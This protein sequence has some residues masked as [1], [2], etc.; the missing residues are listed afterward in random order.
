M[1]NVLPLTSTCVPSSLVL[2]GGFNQAVFAADIATVADGTAPSVYSN[3]SQFYAS[4]YPTQTLRALL[5]DVLARL[6]GDSAAQSVLR[7]DSGLGGGKTHSLIALWHAARGGLGAHAEEFSVPQELRSTP[8]ARTAV[9]VGY[10]AGSGGGGAIHGITPQTIW[11][12]IALQ[13]SGPSGYELIRRFDEELRSPGVDDLKPILHGSPALIVID[14]IANYLES[15]AARPVPNTSFTLDRAVRTFVGQILPQAVSATENISLVITTTEASGVYEDQTRA[16]LSETD[17]LLVRMAGTP[18]PATGEGDIP[19]ILARRLF[20]SVDRSGVGR[21]ADS[22]AALQR[23]AESKGIEFQQSA[24]AFHEQVTSSYPFHPD[25]IT[26]LDKRL[27]TLPNFQRTRGALRLL[28]L[29]VHRAW[30]SQTSSVVLHQWH[31]DLGDEL[32][33]QE[34]TVKL[35]RSRLEPVVRDDVAG[36]PHARAAQITVG[37]E[38]LPVRLATCVLLGSLAARDAGTP[39]S[40]AIRAAMAPGDNAGDAETAIDR[41][42]AESFYLREDDRGLRYSEEPS[43]N[44]LFDTCRR[45]LAPARVEEIATSLYRDAFKPAGLNK[46]F[47]DWDMGEPTDRDADKV[48]VCFHWTKQS[49]GGGVRAQDPV[50]AAVAERWNGPQGKAR[51]NLNNMVLLAPNAE[52]KDKFFDA[53]KDR[54]AWQ[55]LHEDHER[56]ARLSERDRATLETKVK[57]SGMVARVALANYISVLYVPRE[58]GLQ[59]YELPATAAGSI[60]RNQT[61]A[62]ERVLEGDLRELY[63]ADS[64]PL[65]V[66]QLVDQ[67]LAKD[68]AVSRSTEWLAE[69]FCRRPELPI[70]LDPQKLTEFVRNGVVQGRWA[71]RDPNVAHWSWLT[72]ENPDAFPVRIASDTEIAPLHQVPQRPARIEPEPV[73]AP[74]PGG[75]EG[76]ITLPPPPPLPPGA[77]LIKPTTA[78]WSKAAND[79]R[80]E[81]GERAWSKLTATTDAED[82]ANAAQSLRSLGTFAA[83]TTDVP[84]TATVTLHLA[85]GP[86]NV[87]PVVM[88]GPLDKVALLAAQHLANLAAAASDASSSI[89]VELTPAE[90]LLS[91][92]L[93]ALAPLAGLVELEVETQ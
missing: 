13:L 23:E 42:L 15:T 31:L 26:L 89:A 55:D 33:R 66:G 85:F 6:S 43:L 24:N 35:D 10:R 51:I 61:T 57:D 52:H 62:I 27:G 22:Y 40:S 20:E 50:P 78:E 88:H 59:A 14:E 2:Q 91:E 74:E 8:S 25:L 86:V 1:A 4:T 56:V 83:R 60:D 80:L 18:R 58:G 32:I 69:Q 11:G 64:Q 63:R 12:S 5:R 76:P 46:V 87:E 49:I 48:L 67:Y 93:A 37:T 19:H 79:A 77:V 41:L 28:A 3:A 71:Y 68:V 29:A 36:S 16:L 34:L 39:R 44:K 53:V 75:C 21:V 9:F 65:P 81:L 17:S 92:R 30:S 38:A 7:V 82:A 45:T 70:V 84:A 73:S 47:L 90:P 72:A 54:L